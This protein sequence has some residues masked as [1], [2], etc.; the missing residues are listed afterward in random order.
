MN[1][2]AMF[3]SIGRHQRR[4]GI[5]LASL[6]AL[7]AL[8]GFLVLPLV[9]KS[10]I[11]ERLGGMLG[12][13]VTVER[14]RTNPFTLSIT[15]EG[16]QIKDTDAKPLL[17]W[18]RLYVNAKLWP[19][20]KKRL[21]F[22]T[23]DLEQ[24]SVRVVIEKGG[25]L[26]FSDI[27]DR[28]AAKS[29]ASAPSKEPMA[30]F[31]EHL[32]MNGATLAFLDRSLA[33]PFQSTLGPVGFELDR[34]RTE[35]DAHSPYAFKGSTEAGETFA[36]RGTVSTEPL[37]SSGTLELGGLRLRKYAPYYQPQVNFDLRD[38]IATAMAR[39]VC[40]TGCAFML[41]KDGQFST[42]ATM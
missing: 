11:P 32:R 39:S 3:R 28:F 17:A 35:S 24:P 42:S 20:L 9:L 19:L 21:D 15:I 6:V 34:F 36:W 4:L 23:I 33:E 13:E 1:A 40:L 7:Y 25:R 27:L 10:M 30:L 31:I 26:N 18:K 37:R 16:F 41:P 29:P 38:G 2:S 8:A 22:R 12:R 14:I 5:V